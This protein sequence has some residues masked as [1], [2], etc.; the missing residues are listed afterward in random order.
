MR[1]RDALPNSIATLICCAAAFSARHL[2]IGGLG[3]FSGTM[4]ATMKVGQRVRFKSTS[5]AARYWKIPHDAQG[6]VMCSYRLLASNRAAPD[7]IDVR[8]TPQVVIWGAASE[9]FEEIR[10]I[11]ERTMQ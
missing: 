3:K 2:P 11:P 6:T 8:F 1:P 7:R 4:E 5:G 9:D 10:D